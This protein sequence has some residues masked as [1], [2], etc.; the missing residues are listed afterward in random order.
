MPH[1][2]TPFRSPWLLSPPRFGL[3]ASSHH[4]PLPVP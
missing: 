3:V 1:T 4:M 2:L